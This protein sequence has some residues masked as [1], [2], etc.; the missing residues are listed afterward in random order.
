MPS[1]RRPDRVA[2]AIREEVAT[3]LADGAKDPRIVGLVT[4][5]GVDVTQ[6][7]RHAKIFVSV[8]GSDVERRSTLEGLQSAAAHLRS[9]LGRSLRLRFAP[10]LSFQSD[11]SV[12]R[13]ARIETLLEQIRDGR[14]PA[15]EE[16]LD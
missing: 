4:V 13:A 16:P 11:A 7:L 14:V 3:F 10:E 12:A 2:E 9:R 15:D 1:P 8:M 6:D 5:T